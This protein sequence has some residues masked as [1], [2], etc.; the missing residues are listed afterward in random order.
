MQRKN[1]TKRQN[2]GK[3]KPKDMIP[4]PPSITGYEPKHSTT[5][6]FNAGTTFNGSITFQN[7]LDTL[8][9]ATSATVVQDLFY[10]VRIRRVRLWAISAIGT[11][12]TIE[13]EFNG[14]GASQLGNEQIVTDTSMGV[15]P[16]MV[17]ASPS[18][19]TLCGLWQ[20]SSSAVAFTMKLPAGGIIDVE[21][22]LRSNPG[23]AVAAQ[24]AAVA[25]TAGAIYFR[26]LDGLAFAS[27]NLLPA[28]QP[29]A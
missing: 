21:L 16:A 10:S 17:Q 2:N 13:F 5:L 6:R 23:I 24:N 8:L 14:L 27:S 20:T 18:V 25:V 29:V 19:R 1:I 3:N 11:P 9:I 12:A 4:H 15:E 7:L 26:G 28:I 22:S